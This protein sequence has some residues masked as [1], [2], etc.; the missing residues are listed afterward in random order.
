LGHQFRT[1]ADDEVI[2]AAYHQ[3]GADCVLKMNAMWAF[4]IW[5]SALARRPCKESCWKK[6]APERLRSVFNLRWGIG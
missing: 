5:D 1:D 2:L 6:S 3:W 4:G